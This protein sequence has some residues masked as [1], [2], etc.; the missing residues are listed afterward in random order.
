MKSIFLYTNKDY[1][2]QIEHNR[3][4]KKY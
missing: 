3:T 4:K 1:N 2:T